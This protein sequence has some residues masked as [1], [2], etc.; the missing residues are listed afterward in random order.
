MLWDATVA[1]RFR[2]DVVPCGGIDKYLDKTYSD[3]A[4]FLNHI[5]VLCAAFHFL[6]DQIDGVRGVDR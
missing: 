6:P 5:F 1:L 3:Q 2:S 4:T